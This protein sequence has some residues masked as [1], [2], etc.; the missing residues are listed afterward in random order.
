MQAYGRLFVTFRPNVRVGC[1]ALVKKSVFR[2]RS[3]NLRL[4][5]ATFERTSLTFGCQEQRCQ[6][7]EVRQ[8]VCRRH[9]DTV[10]CV[11]EACSYYRTVGRRVAYAA[12]A[13]WSPRHHHQGVTTGLC[14]TELKSDC[15]Q[16]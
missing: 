3:L 10:V 7:S 6:S 16:S 14:H 9:R 13:N 1:H 11:R 2:R 4:R 8:Q 15:C 12:R 5:V